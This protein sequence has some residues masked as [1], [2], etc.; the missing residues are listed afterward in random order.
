MGTKRYPVNIWESDGDWTCEGHAADAPQALACFV[1]RKARD[2]DTAHD[3]YKVTLDG[4]DILDGSPG[5]QRQNEARLRE[6][7]CG[8]MDELGA[9]L[10]R[11]CG[12]W[13]LFVTFWRVTQEG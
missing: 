3:S 10:V 5:W 13:H 7:F 11:G 1:A 9:E 6:H 8:Q 2:G 12:R 4:W